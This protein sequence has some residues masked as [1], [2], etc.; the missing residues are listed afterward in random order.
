MCLRSDIPQTREQN[1]DV[2]E[3]AGQDFSCQYLHQQKEEERRMQEQGLSLMNVSR[4]GCKVDDDFHA[5]E[6]QRSQMSGAVLDFD[7]LLG[8]FFG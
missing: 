1:N 5:A 6:G 2:V 7:L 4:S 8:H 3:E